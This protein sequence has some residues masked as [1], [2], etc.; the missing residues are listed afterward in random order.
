MRKIICIST[1]A[2]A[3]LGST[4]VPAQEP[5][6]T[7]RSNSQRTGHADN[8]PGPIKPNVLWVMKTKEHYIASPVVA[9]DRL[10][11]SGLGGFNTALFTCLDTSAK[12]EKRVLWTKIAPVL[13][14]PTVS[15][16]AVVGDKLIFG[17]GMHQNNGATL[18]CLEVKTGKRVWQLPMPGNLIHMEGSPTVVG[19]VA[20]VGAGSGG[21]I[22]VDINKLTHDGKEV[23]AA[24]AQDVLDKAWKKMEADFELRKA[25]KDP[26][27]VPPSEDRLPKILPKLIWQQGKEKWHVDAPV[28][29]VGGKILIA[30][31]FLDKEKEGDRA[32]FCVDAKSGGI[33]WK[34]PLK[35]N[36]WGGPSV[37]GKTAVVTTSNVNYD[38]TAIGKSNKGS[39]AALDVG[40]GNVIWSKD[41]TGGVV[42]C[43][44]LA[45]G[46]AVV[47]ATDGK[48]RAFELATGERRWIYDTKPKQPFFAPVA[49]AGNVVYAGDLRGVIHAIDLKTGSGLWTL[50]LGV[51][52]SV[53]TPGMIYGGPVIQNGR[54]YVALCNLE[55]AFANQATA[56]VCVGE[57]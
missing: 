2:L 28:A 56:V 41:L 7:Y 53:G 31:A 43:A 17:D 20:Y 5:T 4:R 15:S 39:V 12:I 24:E 11:I 51:D 38:V 29:A 30:S 18:H 19:N 44:A 1:W 13:S 52:K 50:D 33:D 14:Q 3:I 26:F 9:G 6:S 27:A 23:T 22:A 49:I 35:L 21:V 42:S 45:D 25:K 16:P 37:S 40:T 48:V 47:T 34:T 46:A 55:G 57:K 10:F 36:P 8:I 32:V 54:L